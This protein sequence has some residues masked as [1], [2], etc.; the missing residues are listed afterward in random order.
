MRSASNL[1]KPLVRALGRGGLAATALAVAADALA[2]AAC[3]HLGYLF[4]MGV[5][6]WQPAR[7]WYDD[8]VLAAVVAANLLGLAWAG[9]YRMPWRFFG[10]AE[11]SRIVGVVGVVGVVSGVAV[12]SAE[13]SKV[14]RSVLVLHPV[15]SILALCLM[16]MVVR[17]VWEHAQRQAAAAQPGAVRRALLLGAGPSAQVLVQRLRG[18]GGWLVVAAFDDAPELQGR[19]VLGIPVKG[20][21]GAVAE[22]KL[23][24]KVDY[25]IVAIPPAQEA[26]HARAMELAYRTGKTVVPW[27][28]ASV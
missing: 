11:L 25:V 18:Q 16:R 22:S 17:V 13:L 3:W 8:Y 14:A 28:P 7:P 24:P 5:E 10:F 4:R 23:L 19:S 26:E 21:L 27:E 15:F 6:R 12:V 1:W 9:L 20:R 2:L